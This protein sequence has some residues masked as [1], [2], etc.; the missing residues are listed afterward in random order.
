MKL[1]GHL[2]TPIWY[3]YRK[4][5]KASETNEH[6]QRKIMNNYMDESWLSM[7]FSKKGTPNKWSSQEIHGTT[8]ETIGKHFNQV[9]KSLR[10]RHDDNN[11][12]R[13]YI[14][15]NLPPASYTSLV[16]CLVGTFVTIYYRPIHGVSQSQLNNFVYELFDLASAAR[17]N[18]FPILPHS[19]LRF[20]F[21][22]LFIHF[23]ANLVS[24]YAAWSADP[25]GQSV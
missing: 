24:M 4:S 21:E 12:L 10:R 7:G 9:K 15:T 13:Q 2:S 16:E 5:R 23:L 17:E 22:A 20:I 19:S 6:N 18:M 8:Q 25:P 3:H 1:I 14:K 11:N